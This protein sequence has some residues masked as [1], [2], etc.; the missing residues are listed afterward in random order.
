MSLQY[1]ADGTLVTTV[2]PGSIETPRQVRNR[3][4]EAEIK[5][6]SLDELL[7]VR[8]KDIP[9]QRLGRPKWLPSWFFWR[10]S[11]RAT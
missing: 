7:K 2:A 10:P 1:A 5:G 8:V 6:T 11:S 9:L 3:Q 4:R